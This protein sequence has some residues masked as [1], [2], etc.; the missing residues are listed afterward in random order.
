MSEDDDCIRFLFTKPPIPTTVL[1]LDALYYHAAIQCLQRAREAEPKIQEALHRFEELRVKSEQVLQ[2]YNQD[3]LEGYS[4]LEPIYIQMDGA[5]E[6]AG[7]AYSP[8]LE[9]VASAHILCAAALEGHINS[10]ASELLAGK[11][12]QKFEFLDLEFKWLLLPKLLGKEGFDV[13]GQPF[14]VF[15]KLIK[16][17][18]K[19]VHYKQREE[20]RT[21]N[22][23]PTSLAD[24]GLTIKDAANSVSCVGEMISELARQLGQDVPYWLQREPGE[25][26][27]FE[28]GYADAPDD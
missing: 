1:I 7:F 16:F 15:A 22:G 3:A 2:E 25:I 9:A 14:Q 13:G 6:S 8:L 12:Q 21:E 17:R 18:N 11:L 4:E 28:F 19:L 27:C 26:S 5:S 20:H 24:L 23:I 10:R